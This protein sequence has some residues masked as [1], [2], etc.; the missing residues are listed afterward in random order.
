MGGLIVDEEGGTF[1]TPTRTQI[2]FK[3]LLLVIKLLSLKIK[4]SS[5]FKRT[6]DVCNLDSWSSKERENERGRWRI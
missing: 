6:R 3:M 4:L 5:I 2:D 1:E